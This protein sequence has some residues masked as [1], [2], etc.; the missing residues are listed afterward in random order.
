MESCD[1]G[2]GSY[3]VLGWVTH[4]AIIGTGEDRKKCS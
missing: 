2:I 4:S 1:V 3:V